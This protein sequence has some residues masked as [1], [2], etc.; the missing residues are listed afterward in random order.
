MP[1][2]RSSDAASGI[3]TMSLIPSN[4]SAPPYLPCV[5]QVA[6]E[7]VPW[8]A[9]PEQILYDRAAS[10]VEAVRGDETRR[11]GERDPGS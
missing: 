1:D 10:F 7:T 9:L 2:V 6:P 8:L 11:C 3:F 4:W 5:V